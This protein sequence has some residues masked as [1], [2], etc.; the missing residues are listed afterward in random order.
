MTLRG[1]GLSI[2]V[3]SFL[4]CFATTFAQES[5]ATCAG[6]PFAIAF[7]DC[8]L[9]SNVVSW[10]ALVQVGSPNPQRVCLIPSTVTNSTVV[11]QETLCDISKT[12]IQNQCESLR[13]G[14][15][16][17]NADPSWKAVSDPQNSNITRQNPTWDLFNPDGP[18][19]KLGWDT[20]RYG[21]S[22]G[23]TLYGAGIA[24]NDKGNQS[25]LGMIGLGIE[26]TF[27]S[28][29]VAQGKSPSRS[30]GF[31][32]GST[33]SPSRT[34]ELVI[35]GYNNARLD[36]PLTWA[37]LSDMSGGRPCPLRT[38][39][40]ATSIR[41]ANGTK[42]DITSSGERYTACIEPYDSAFRWTPAMVANWKQVTNYNKS[43]S[44]VYAAAGQ[45]LSFVEPGLLYASDSIPE[46]DLEITISSGY[47]TVIPS[48]DFQR[49]LTGYNAQGDLQ[50]VENVTN[51]AIFNESTTGG[52]VGTLGR[53]FLSRVSIRY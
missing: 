2:A 44:D 36:G 27:L 49:P 41:L 25:N 38:E 14:F 32:P 50:A 42:L 18:L 53:I 5:D 6:K 23:V 3:V 47:R 30:W 33:A 24:V 29:A 12:P 10:G 34:G 46:W 45:N 39:I 35:G 51:V 13:G 1:L 15:Y 7:G 21:S 52:Q 19:V 4:T 22:D 31:D 17:E 9:I 8:R 28:E 40:I 37:N 43:L 11:Q 48:K 16:D 26:S 20:V